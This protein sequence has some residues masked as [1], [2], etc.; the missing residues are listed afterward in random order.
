MP[1]HD[2]AAAGFGSGAR[3]LRAGPARA[4]RPTPWRGSWTALV[5]GP[6]SGRRPGRRD[7]QADPAPR[8]ERGVA[9][10]RRAGRGHAPGPRRTQPDVPA[11]VAGTAEALPLAAGSVDAVTVAQAFHWFDAEAAFAELAR[12]LRP[13]GRVGLIWNAR[14]RH[15]GWVTSCGRS[16]TGSRN[17]R[18]GVTTSAGTTPTSGL[19]PASGRSTRRPSTMSSASTPR[20]GSRA[21]SRRSATSRSA[22][23]S[24]AA[25]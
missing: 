21:G 7:R 6:A 11:V 1:V 8:A 17:A 25:R 13:G 18:R 19:G 3:R 16:W 20:R 10:R 5:S 9:R 14:D 22:R 12:V 4:I 15:V 24:A 23:G 2:V